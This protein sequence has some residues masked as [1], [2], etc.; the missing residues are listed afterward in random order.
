MARTKQAAR[1]VELTVRLNV[2]VDPP[3]ST[4][5]KARGRRPGRRCPG[6]PQLASKTTKRKPQTSATAVSKFSQSLQ[7]SAKPSTSSYGGRPRYRPGMFALREIRAYQNSGRLLLPKAPFQRLVRS[8]AED[9]LK[10]DQTFRFQLSALEALQEAAEAYL[11]ELFEDT[12][13]CAV[14]AKRVTIM[15]SDMALARRLRGDR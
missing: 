9:R 2:H 13:L 11:V 5:K 7:L 14:H 10:V 12:N 15:P 1:K 8:I 3:S 6:R 4:S